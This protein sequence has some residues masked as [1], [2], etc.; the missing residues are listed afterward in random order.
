[1]TITAEFDPANLARVET[2]IVA[3]VRRLRDG[4]ITEDERRR[5]VTAAEAAHEFSLETAEG[6]A[7][8]LGRAESIWRL[9]EERAWV[10]RLRSVDRGQIMTVV[11]RYLDPARYVRLSVMPGRP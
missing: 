7:F 1:V 10:D 11:R 8:A 9:E 3:E 5:A 6:R 4:G 2:G